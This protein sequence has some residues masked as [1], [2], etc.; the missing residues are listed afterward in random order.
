ML[1]SS[2]CTDSTTKFDKAWPHLQGQPIEHLLGRWGRADGTA[3]ARDNMGTVYIW[4]KGLQ[5]TSTTPVT[6]TGTIGATPF[7]V[8]T[9]MPQTDSLTCRALVLVDDARRIKSLKFSGNNGACMKLAE[10]L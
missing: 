5:Y 7:I 4:N 10:Q 3:Q 9:E 2:G 8:T 6:S 1:A